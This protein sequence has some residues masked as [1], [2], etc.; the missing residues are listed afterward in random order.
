[1]V[2]RASCQ[3]PM[4]NMVAHYYP[5]ITLEKVIE[6]PPFHGMPLLEGEHEHDW[7]IEEIKIGGKKIVKL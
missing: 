3:I 7:K 4:C 1:M 5:P 2:V 6:C